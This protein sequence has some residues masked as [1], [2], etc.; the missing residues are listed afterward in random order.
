M[1]IARSG[2]PGI[3]CAFI[4]DRGN[5][6]MQ[7]L[8]TAS[9]L[10]SFQLPYCATL[11]G[12]QDRQSFKRGTGIK[13]NRAPRGFGIFQ[14]VYHQLTFNIKKSLSPLDI[15]EPRNSLG[16][17]VHQRNLPI[18]AVQPKPSTEGQVTW[19]PW[20]TELWSLNLWTSWRGDI[21]AM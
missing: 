11:A 12:A 18:C 17:N 7:M 4:T 13:T 19:Q 16:S 3:R 9:Y 6:H 5:V 21:Q 2:P 8:E 10:R 20:N 1:F 15:R 14:Q